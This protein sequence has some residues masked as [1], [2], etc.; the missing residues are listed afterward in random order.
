M[1]LNSVALQ[2]RL[3]RHW[4]MNVL[5]VAAY[6]AQKSIFVEG[7]D[8]RENF[9]VE[10]ASDQT[11]LWRHVYAPRISRIDGNEVLVPGLFPGQSPAIS[12]S[13]G[14]ENFALE[15]LRA[16]EAHHFFAKKGISSKP[17]TIALEATS[18]KWQHLSRAKFEPVL[19]ADI[20]QAQS[21]CALE[22]E[23]IAVAREVTDKQAM[24]QLFDYIHMVWSAGPALE[25][26]QTALDI[27]LQ[28]FPRGVDS[29]SVA[30][31]LELEEFASYC[32]LRA[33]F[34]LV[35]SGFYCEKWVDVAAQPVETIRASEKC[36]PGRIVQELENISQGRIAPLLVNE[37]GCVAD[38][39]HRLAAAWIWNMLHHCREL[40]WQTGCA[41]FEAILER[42]IKSKPVSHSALA[43]ANALEGLS[44]ILNSRES[45]Q[46]LL[47]LKDLIQLHRIERLPVVPIL[48]YNGL[49]VDRHSFESG[50]KL[51]RFA[52]KHYVDLQN[53]SNTFL[54]ARACYHF[55][56]RVPLPWFSILGEADEAGAA[57]VASPYRL[58]F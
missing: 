28:A 42:F 1:P 11:S 3:P 50:G 56:D 55:A 34:D 17:K 20:S 7:V 32:T 51:E 27:A 10:H 38:G 52:P 22:K 45:R 2:Q 41:S 6:A 35:T 4:Q 14:K 54:P 58:W 18:W 49:A 44:S 25:Y 8:R 46:H 21:I 12:Q 47:R 43:V 48:S 15:R 24:V 26:D 30:I 33:K 39:N 5:D 23:I 37:F 19:C 29:R 16:F 53:D 9:F 40:D 57:A 36:W 13:Y 31:V